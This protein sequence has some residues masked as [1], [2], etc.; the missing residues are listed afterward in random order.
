MR[1]ERS[2]RKRAAAAAAVEYIFLFLGPSWSNGS[3][4]PL[5]SSELPHTLILIRWWGLQSRSQRSEKPLGLI[6][7]CFFSAKNIKDKNISKEYIYVRIHIDTTIFICP[8]CD[9]NSLRGIESATRS[10]FDVASLERESTRER[11]EESG[12]NKKR[13]GKKEKKEKKKKTVI[14][15]M[16][17]EGI[18]SSLTTTTERVIECIYRLSTPCPCLSLPPHTITEPPSSVKISFYIYATTL[19]YIFPMYSIAV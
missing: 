13:K 2:S 5:I 1:Y 7:V 3:L 8:P 18:T 17:V 19:C 9:S 14:L 10:S 4:L 11:T 6:F 15:K 12:N 16:N